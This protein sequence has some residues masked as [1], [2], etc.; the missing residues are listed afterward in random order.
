M[1]HVEASTSSM[2]HVEASTSSMSH[3]EAS[4]WDKMDSEYITF[5]YQKL[6]SLLNYHTEDDKTFEIM[7][8]TPR[9]LCMPE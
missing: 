9:Q 4:M 1:S 7:G 6:C 5:L 8:S 3:V 2:S